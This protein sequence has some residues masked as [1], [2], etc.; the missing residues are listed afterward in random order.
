MMHHHQL[1]RI[2]SEQRKNSAQRR[3]VVHGIE[4]NYLDRTRVEVVYDMRWEA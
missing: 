3:A 4:I 2:F 1:L